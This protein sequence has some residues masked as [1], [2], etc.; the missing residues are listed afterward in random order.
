MNVWSCSSISILTG[1]GLAQHIFFSCGQELS[2]WNILL[3]RPA[4]LILKSSYYH[5]G[6]FKEI[7]SYCNQMRNESKI[8]GTIAIIAVTQFLLS[9]NYQLLLS[10]IY[11]LVFALHLSHH[12]LSSVCFHFRG[13]WIKKIL[14]NSKFSQILGVVLLKDRIEGKDSNGFP[15]CRIKYRNTGYHMKGLDILENSDLRINGDLIKYL[16]LVL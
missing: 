9:Q 2:S 12:S 8:D 14:E 3:A 4:S 6:F 15:K 13:I 1:Q 7:E 5:L 11:I 10:S 16:A